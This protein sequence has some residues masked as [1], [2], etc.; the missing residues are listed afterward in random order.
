VC[1]DI[2]AGDRKGTHYFLIMQ[3][4]LEMKESP[5]AAAQIST[6]PL[7]SK[8]RKSDGQTLRRRKSEIDMSFSVDSGAS[9]TT[10]RKEKLKLDAEIVSE[11][12]QK[13]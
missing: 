11:V 9:I 12:C 10:R 4:I 5:F 8:K 3:V 6:Q 2:I 7:S 13:S 1:S